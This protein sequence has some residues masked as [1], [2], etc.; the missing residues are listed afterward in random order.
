MKI[1]CENIQ[2][3]FPMLDGYLIITSFKIKFVNSTKE[4]DS[5]S[6]M[7]NAIKK[8]I[9]FPS[10][11][12]EYL[13]VPLGLILKVEKTTLER[14]T[15]KISYLEMYTK[16]HRYLKLHFDNFNDC[17]QVNDKI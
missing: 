8:K 2:D 10:Y 12:N 5:P 4:S 6:K 17:N 15:T 9:K 1:R 3:K 11:L 13:T 14:K 16:D 7:Q